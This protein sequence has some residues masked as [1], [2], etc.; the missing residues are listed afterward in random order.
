MAIEHLAPRRVMWVFLF[1]HI[2]IMKITDIIEMSLPVTKLNL[3]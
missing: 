1:Y 3:V 2:L